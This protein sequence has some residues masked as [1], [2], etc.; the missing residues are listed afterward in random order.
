MPFVNKGFEYQLLY[1][2]AILVAPSVP[3]KRSSAIV[4][5]F[6]LGITSVL[7]HF[8]HNLITGDLGNGEYVERVLLNLFLHFSD[9]TDT[10]SGSPV[11]LLRPVNLRRVAAVAS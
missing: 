4:V 5:I 8:S 9:Q 11:G 1:T 10:V 3:S 6:S 2:R 7:H